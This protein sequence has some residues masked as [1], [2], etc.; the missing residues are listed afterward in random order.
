MPF[1]R[2]LIGLLF[3]CYMR[4]DFKASDAKFLVST[5]NQVNCDFLL[6][7]IEELAKDGIEEIE[8]DFVLDE[9]SID[10][11]ISLGFKCS[12][13]NRTGVYKYRISWHLEEN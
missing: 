1:I 3:Y 12:L 11:F 2:L 4:R 10:F 8:I 9:I 7:E 5:R 13:V 6:K